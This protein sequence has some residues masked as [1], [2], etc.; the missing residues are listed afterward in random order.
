MKANGLLSVTTTKIPN[1]KPGRV[2]H[3]KTDLFLHFLVCVCYAVAWVRL[4]FQLLCVNQFL[5]GQFQVSCIY[6]K[7]R[8]CKFS[9]Y[10]RYTKAKTCI[11]VKGGL[12]IPTQDSSER[13]EPAIKVWFNLTTL[14][15]INFFVSYW[16][17]M[18]QTMTALYCPVID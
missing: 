2:I 5:F 17:E 3:S 14:D 18:R 7:A 12:H 11:D 9:C 15:H 8:L 13:G 10:S 4:F 16:T 6:W 1:N